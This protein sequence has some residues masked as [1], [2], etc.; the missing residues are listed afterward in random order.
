MVVTT[1]R[2]SH[3]YV[4]MSPVGSK[5]KGT[6]LTAESGEY[7]NRRSHLY[8]HMSPVGSKIKGT[9]LTAGSD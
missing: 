9:L 8:V 3:L 2:R 4:H 5:I 7:I 1:D 6:L